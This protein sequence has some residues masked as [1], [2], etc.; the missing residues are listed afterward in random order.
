MVGR[1]FRRTLTGA[2]VAAAVASAAAAQG[3]PNNTITIGVL[4]DMAGAGAHLTG[5]GAVA[6]TR[7]AVEDCLKAECAGLT[8]QVLTADHQNKPDIALTQARKW[9]DTQGVQVLVDMSNASIQLAMPPLLREKNRLGLFMGGTSRLTGDACEPDH[10]V[11]WMWDSYA[12]VAAVT[13]RLTKLNTSWYLV[14]ADY[15]LG[16]QFEADAR[17][18]VSAKGGRVLGSVRHPFGTNDFASFLFSA[19]GSGADIVALANGGTD[20]LN[21]LKTARDFSMTGNKKQK[22]VGFLLTNVEV[23][24]LGLEVAQGTTVAEGFYGDLD[25]GTRAFTARFK[26]QSGKVPSTIQAGIYSAVRHYLKAVAA[27]RSDEAKVVLAKMRELPIVD[28]IV[29][30]GRLREDGRMLHDFYL[31]EVK[32]PAAS[33]SPDDIYDLVATIPG[34]EAFK[35]IS[36]ACTRLAR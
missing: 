12:Q 9:I 31:L 33:K 32:S 18:L 7:F 2:L 1:R 36:P 4:T 22:L 30:N 10:L 8:I 17:A 14:A 28:D 19:Q 13:G 34:D 3:I 16:H 20:T 21:A 35:P 23:A 25:E 29:R 6:A 15:A 27:A 5:T 24:S 26:A 11:Q